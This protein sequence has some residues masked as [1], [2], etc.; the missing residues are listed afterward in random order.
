M[1]AGWNWTVRGKICIFIILMFLSSCATVEDRSKNDFSNVK[2]N[3][4][5][6]L[7]DFEGAKSSPEWAKKQGSFTER[8][9]FFVVGSSYEIKDKEKSRQSA[10][11][12]GLSE[13]AMYFGV[14]VKSTL[15]DIQKDSSGNYSYEVSTKSQITSRKV[16]INR[17]VKVDEF[18][19]KKDGKYTTKVL[20]K[21]PEKEVRRIEKEILGVTAWNIFIKD[22]KHDG[23]INDFLKVYASE[24]GLNLGSR[25]IVQKDSPIE[26]LAATAD[27]AY[28][29]IVDVD[30]KDI[31]H[32]GK[33]YFTKIKLLIT[34]YSLTENKEI[35]SVIK[36]MKWGE[37]TPEEAVS[38][39]LKKVME[40]IIKEGRLN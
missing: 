5:R 34:L 23:M 37:Y 2:K 26:E 21:M 12:N 20:I 24:N 11:S 1:M 14:N 28:F 4:D 33:A 16:Q 19:E 3:A 36:E 8:G 38:R 13:L 22:R 15:N 30:W 39:G 9:C 6:S 32:E 40:K 31:I 10:F 29:L 17:V 27:T 18:I 25:V 35:K 7:N